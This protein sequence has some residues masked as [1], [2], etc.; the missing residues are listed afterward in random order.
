MGDAI[1]HA[2]LPGIVLA[3]IA[4]IPLVVGAF[5]SGMVCAISTGFISDNS[6]VKEDTVMGVVF[7]GL[8]ALGIVLYTAI[9]TELHLD[10]ILFGDMLGINRLD[11]ISTAI[12]AVIV[13]VILLL[14]WKDFLLHTFD[15]QQAKATGF[16]V[17]ILHYTL[18]TMLSL[19][20]VG[21]LKS[22]GLILAIALF[23]SP[24]AIAYLWVKKFEHM[25]LL[26]VII[27]AISTFIGIYASFFLDSAP[28]PTIILVMASFF[29]IAFFTRGRISRSSKNIEAIEE[30]NE[31]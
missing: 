3:F 17:R 15:N 30:P 23:I 19:T 14:R 27:C 8:F 1:S 12:I 2:V 29:I 24:G 16:S 26:S 22:V 11:L 10:H 5:V 4:G 25:L 6:R 13:S 7:S 20:I 31:I 28:A 21:V 18:L 9:E